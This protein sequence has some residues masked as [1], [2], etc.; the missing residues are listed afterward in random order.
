MRRREAGFIAAQAAIF[1]GVIAL[2]SL[3]LQFSNN[4]QVSTSSTV[5]EGPI[6]WQQPPMSP[7]ILVLHTPEYVEHALNRTIV[8]PNATIL[9]PSYR[10]IGVRIDGDPNFVANH[11]SEV[12]ATIYVWNGTFTNGSTT[13]QDVLDGKGIAIVESPIAPGGPDSAAAAQAMIAPQETC[14]VK[15]GVSSCTTDSTTTSDSIVTQNGLSIV[16]NPSGSQLT[17]VDDKRLVI[18]NIVGGSRT[19]QDVL[20]VAGS[21]T[22]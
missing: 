7:L 18:V 6:P 9:G 5:S 3:P 22:G 19:I 2:I 15:D 11:T 4:T 8:L 17:W 10:I 13:V 12:A 14:V 21:M 20:L 16:V 1:V